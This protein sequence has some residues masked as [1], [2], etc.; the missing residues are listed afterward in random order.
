MSE[1]VEQIGCPSFEVIS[2]HLDGEAEA[3]D[4]TH[5]ESCQHCLCILASLR[6]LD[7]VV[8]RASQPPQGLSA[9]I[10]A[11]CAA[12]RDHAAPATVTPFWGRSLLRYAAALAITAGL[13]FAVRQS[14]GNGDSAPDPGKVAMLDNGDGDGS[15]PDGP[16]IDPTNSSPV[17]TREGGDSA[18]ITVPVVKR[19]VANQ[20][21]HVWGVKDLEKVE[22]DV[23]TQLPEGAK[24]GVSRD[25][26]GIS[27][28]ASL[29]DEQLQKLVNGIHD[30]GYDLFR[31]ELPQPNQE[32]RVKFMGGS[33][34]VIYLARFVST[35]EQ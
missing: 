30:R 6:D 12:D 11:A 5:I 35:N 13:A 2:A 24:W 17:S 1:N 21:R 33:R 25:N 32:D 19:L 4:A 34:K 16:Q 14:V 3:G 31:S 28:E 26:A 8:A 18:A 9:R 20:V 7:K 27:V 22:K 10:L 23:A 29:T 15:N